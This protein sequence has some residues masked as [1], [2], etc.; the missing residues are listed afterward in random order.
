MKKKILALAFLGVA[1]ALT[2][3]GG[4]ANKGSTSGPKV[5]SSAQTATTTNKVLS[6]EGVPSTMIGNI[7]DYYVNTTNYDVY[8]KSSSGWT[9]IDNLKGEKGDKG[10]TGEK[11]DKGERGESGK[12]GITYV[13]CIFR[14]YDGTTLYTFY[15]AQG[16]SAVYEGE[17]PIKPDTTVDGH[18]AHWTFKG[19]DKSLDNV[20]KPTIFTAQYESLVSVVFKNYDGS[21]L[22]N[23]SIN[24]GETPVYEGETPTKPSE[25]DGSTTIEWT[26]DGWDKALGPIYEDTVYT[27]TFNSP[28]AIKCTF[29]ND[30]GSPLGVSYCGVGGKAVYNGETPTKEEVNNNGVI[31]R[32][33]FKGWDKA[34]TNIQTATTFTAQY[35]SAPYYECKFYDYDET[36]LARVVVPQNG[37]AVYPNATPTRDS[38]VSGSQITDYAFSKW[39][40]TTSSITSPST[41]KAVYSENSYEG[42]MVTYQD[43][44]GKELCKKGVATGEDA[45]YPLSLSD[46]IDACY[47]YDANNVTMFWGWD[48]DLTNVSKAL[49]VKAK[50]QTL[51]RH[52]NGEWPQTLVE[53]V[54]L[55]KKIGASATD[56]QGYY[57]YNGE[58]YQSTG[59]EIG[60]DDDFDDDGEWLGYIF[61]YTYRKVEPSK[62]RYLTADSTGAVQVV[63]ERILTYIEW[64]STSSDYEDGTHANNYAKSD[65]RTWLNGTFLETAFY[66]DQTLIQTTE[67]DN[68]ASTTPYSNNPYC[69]QNTSDKVFLLNYQD[70][71]NKAYG[72]TDD[73]SRLAYDLD[74]NPSYWWLRSPYYSYSDDA[75]CVG[76]SGDWYSY[77][78]SNSEGARPS[79][80]LKVAE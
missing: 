76:S 27:A 38:D 5:D 24:F 8:E 7:G 4:N 78:V 62:W 17:T 45:Y 40:G 15:F 3:C 35:E 23:S 69:C 63:S 65:I 10:D 29:V 1:L 55:C 43:F 46:L 52:Q 20:Q 51:S 57:Q 71:Y 60:C 25:V 39:D 36:Y 32:Y 28:N 68:S 42:Y 11:G 47:S 18:T 66:Y 19:W 75:Y 26:F 21:T 30:D 33:T 80:R 67:V 61:I 53:D 64:N 37:T 16:T 73:A 54:E 70:V 79:L 72:F 14:N 6:G 44:D 9:L 50:K 13:P 41:F 2:G 31:T 77:W 48:K 58:R 49:T 59:V 34:V 22:Q 74:G 12:D 56:G